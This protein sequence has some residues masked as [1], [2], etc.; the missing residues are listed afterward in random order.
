MLGR[1]GTYVEEE[2][3]GDEDK[4]TDGGHAAKFHQ[5]PVPSIRADQGNRCLDRGQYEGKDQPE[6]TGFR[7]HG[8]VPGA[9]VPPFGPLAAGFHCPDFFKASATSLAIN[10]R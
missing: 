4:L 10:R 3:G 9:A 5:H 7:D 8:I 6:V 1:Y 2:R